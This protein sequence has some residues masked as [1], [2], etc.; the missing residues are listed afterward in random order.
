MEVHKP[1][2]P[3]A[4]RITAIQPEVQQ[5]TILLCKTSECTMASNG[6]GR[7][8]RKT[9]PLLDPEFLKALAEDTPNTTLQ[10]TTG[11]VNALHDCQE[12]FISQLTH[13]LAE[14]L[15]KDKTG[16][17]QENDNGNEG[18]KRR[19][20]WVQPQHVEAAMTAMGLTDILEEARES[21]LQLEDNEQEAEL[22]GGP[23]K[24]KRKKKTWKKKEEFS[25]EMLAEQERLLAAALQKKS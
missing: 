1:P 8:Q 15:K 23:A 11:G 24:K 16:V 9:A 19:I 4:H 13:H 22:E 18:G 12:E 21:I 10:L 7:K 14:A 20:R 5:T 2:E 25:A 6:N 17:K 3:S